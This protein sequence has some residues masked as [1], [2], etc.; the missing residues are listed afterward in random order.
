MSLA[1]LL[2]K[3][4]RREWRSKEALQAGLVL[5]ALFLVLYLFAFPTLHDAPAT[6]AVVL[7]TPIL[8]GAAAIAGRA[9]SAE[10]DRGT[11]TLLRL[12]PVS[13]VWHGVSRTLTDLLVLAALATFTV[14]LASLIFAVPSPP[15]LWLIIGLGVIGLGTIGSLTGAIA[16]QARARELL[17]PIL[18]VPVLMPLLQA[19]LVATQAAFGG[20][21]DRTALLLLAGYDLVAIGAAW[22]LWP[23]VL[24]SD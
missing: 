8:Y 5:V 2:W 14:A 17:V 10:A 18:M 16:A 9:S 21:L 22:L 4:L 6:A 19:G 23:L 20:E 24:E 12:A 11:L 15:A 1:A 13:R 7:W 3:D